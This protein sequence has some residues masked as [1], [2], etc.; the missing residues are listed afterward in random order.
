MHVCLVSEVLSVSAAV[1][2]ASSEAVVTYVGTRSLG[3][4][5]FTRRTAHAER[6][7]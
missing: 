2:A 6:L 5:L 4:I 3:R 7:V 1:A